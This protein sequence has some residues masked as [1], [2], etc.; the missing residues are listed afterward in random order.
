EV[1][2]LVQKTKTTTFYVTHDQ[3]EAMTLGDRVAVLDKGRLQQVAPPRDLYTSP[4]NVFVA[5]FIGNPPMNLFPS[6]LDVAEGREVLRVSDQ[7]FPA[8]DPPPRVPRRVPLTV[9]VRPEA[10]RIGAAGPGTLRAV[11]EQVEN[12]GHETL[13]HVR[14]GDVALVARVEGMAA[15]AIGE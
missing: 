11:V 3:V 2:E 4:A 6:R 10:L 7:A 13:A 5:G 15:V 14:V 9:G 8:G 1:K 12:L